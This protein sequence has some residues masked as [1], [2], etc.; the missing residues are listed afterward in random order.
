[1]PGELP[2]QWQTDFDYPWM[3]GWLANQ[4]GTLRERNLLVMITGQGP[5]TGVI[6]A[7]SL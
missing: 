2:F 4:Q 5:Q 3:D 1:L 6:M 7:E